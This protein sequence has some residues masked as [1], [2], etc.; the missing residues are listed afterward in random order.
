M[1]MGCANGQINHFTKE[2]GKIISTM[3]AANTIGKMAADTPVNGVK[4]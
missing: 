1:G 2:N 4:V 3:G